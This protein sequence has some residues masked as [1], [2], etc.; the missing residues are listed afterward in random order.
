MFKINSI[1]MLN[2]KKILI[3]AAHPDD[4]IL[5][6]GGMI[7]KFK[8]L[9]IDFKIIFIAEGS[10][11][12]FN[13]IDDKEAEEAIRKRNAYA[14]DVMEFIGIKNFKFYN[15]PCGRLDEIPIIEINKIIEK[16]IN[17]YS[18][19]AVFTHSLSDCNND[20]KIIYNS[21]LMATRPVPK[22][23]VINLYS[24][25]ILTSSEWN[26]EN[27]FQPNYF[28]KLDDDDLKM[29]IDTINMY[30]SEIKEY[31]FP[32]SSEGIKTLAM[33]R[34]MQVGVKYAEAFKLIR[35][36]IL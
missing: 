21:S 34:G 2:F 13:S 29:K 26:F 1:L 11:C 12:R 30:K 23:K 19:D 33:F 16:N 17:E 22:N 7:S 15:L 5:G 6:C 28:L 4:E 24:F 35:Q 36:T 14:I 32:R 27:Q 25:E 18:P 8:K 31:P 10:T 3:I 9:D 20:H